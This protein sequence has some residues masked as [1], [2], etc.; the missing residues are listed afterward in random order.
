MRF[1]NS[2]LK[3]ISPLFSIAIVAVLAIALFSCDSGGETKSTPLGEWYKESDFDGTSRSNAVLFM[4]GETP[5]L[6]TGFSQPQNTTSGLF[7]KDFYAYSSNK[8]WNK[9]TSEFPGKA[10]SN[11]VA[12]SING[13]GYVGLGF[14]GTDYLS[15]F[16]EYDPSLNTWT[17]IADFPGA[18]RIGAVS[19]AVD[20]KG[21]VGAGSDGTNYL[22]DLY[23]YD[24][25]SGTWAV[26]AGV[27]GSKRYNAFSFVIGSRAFVGG[28]RGTDGT[29]QATLWEYDAAADLW[30]EKN[31]L[32][33][34]KL[35]DDPNDKDYNIA[36]EQAVTFVIN[37]YGYVM[38]GA[39]GN[40]L[41]P[42]VWEYN[43]DTDGWIEKNPFEGASRVGAVGFSLGDRGYIT[44][45]LSGNNRYEDMWSFDPTAIDVD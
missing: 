27:G 14:D 9:L 4:I 7:L 11:A 21:Y 43:P 12:F 35:D 15:D 26:K 6:G 39:T 42:Q 37:G 30:T 28:G 44:T 23:A 13:K 1:Y 3:W 20:G 22:K 19:F 45:G 25:T 36:R 33:E 34:D 2:I 38:G 5:Y 16:Y 40:V 18:P 8:S 29:M 24:P 41:S 32:K 17:K 31:D 10:R